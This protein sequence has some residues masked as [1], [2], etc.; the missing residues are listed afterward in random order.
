[1]AGLGDIYSLFRPP[2]PCLLFLFTKEKL[3]KAGS[4]TRWEKE[5]W[6]AQAVLAQASSFL[7]LFQAFA[8]GTN[9]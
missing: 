3:E 9:S 2:A 7:A 5:Y 1:M 4:P 8:L 6:L